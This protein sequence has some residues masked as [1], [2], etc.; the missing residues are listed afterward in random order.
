MI[1]RRQFLLAAGLLPL[2]HVA[3]AAVPRVVIVGGGWGGL[4][5]ARHLRQLAP[6][7]EVLLL[8][9]QP[10]FHSFALSNR[11]LVDLGETRIERQDYAAL[12]GRWGYRFVQ[13]EVG[14]VDRTRRVVTTSA[15]EFAYD[16]L[17]LSPGI[18]E[19]FAAWQVDDPERVGE[20]RR[21]FGGGMLNAA[22]LPALKA[23][24]A[25]FRGGDLLLTIPPAP[26]RCPPAPYERAMLLAWWLKTRRIPGRLVIVDPN[27]MMPAFRT[28]LL[29]RFREQVRYIDHAHLRQVDLERRIA[30]TD[31]DDI[32]FDEALFSPPQTAASLLAGAGL[33]RRDDQGRS[34]GW[35]A[36]GAL[37]FRSAADERIFIIGDA[38]GVVSPLFGQYPKTGHVA[39]RM[40]M[41]VAREIAAQLGGQASAPLWPESICHVLSSVEPQ[42]NTRIETTYRR[43]GDGFPVQQVKQLRNPNPDGEDAAWAEAMY[44]DFL[45]A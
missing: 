40:G 44:R 25:N 11:W 45:R 35:G 37:D 36:Q 24:L 41:S 3:G 38:A 30:S 5:V 39:H 20:L 1:H 12:A 18:H 26:Y 7:A 29:D 4:T 19:N 15:G 32:P 34:D 17:V 16:W 33:L 27:P 2:I 10:A 14:G 28:I 22:E 21:R 9:R 23:R 43:R 31:I 13:A 6:G 8:D 42:E